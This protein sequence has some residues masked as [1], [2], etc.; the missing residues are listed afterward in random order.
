MNRTKQSNNIPV[1]TVTSTWEEIV[2]Y[3]VWLNGSD[4]D[5]HIDD[6]P[7]DMFSFN[8]EAEKIIMNNSTIM[9]GFN[10]RDENK[11]IT[12][13]E[14]SN[15]LWDAFMPTIDIEVRGMKYTQES[16]PNF[17][18]LITDNTVIQTEIDTHKHGQH[19]HFYDMHGDVIEWDN[20]TTNLILK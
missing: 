19:V 1:L 8:E 9:W 17:G 3:L 18:K 10:Q 14:M 20:G 5:Y 16:H 12:D 2:S 4:F 15:M 13:R 6:D 7:S 11:H